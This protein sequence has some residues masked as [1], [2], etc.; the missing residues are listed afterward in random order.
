[1]AT[2]SIEE[3]ITIIEDNQKLNEVKDALHKPDK[4]YADVQ[5][6]IKDSAT[7][8]VLDKWFSL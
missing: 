2:I 6:A 1:M 3:K 8:E 7:K 5:P 4:A